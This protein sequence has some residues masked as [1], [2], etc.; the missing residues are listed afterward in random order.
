MK[1]GDLLLWVVVVVV[2]TV[3]FNVLLHSTGGGRVVH[4]VDPADASEVNRAFHAGSHGSDLLDVDPESHVFLTEEEAEAPADTSPPN[5][6]AAPRPLR[7]IDY[8]L[9]P[10]SSTKHVAAF[11][12][13]SY[14]DYIARAALTYKSL[15]G[16]RFNKKS[17]N[18]T[19]EQY[20]KAISEQPQC[21][22]KPVFMSM[23]RVSSD[24]YW[25]LIENFFH[26]MYYFGNVVSEGQPSM[27][28]S[29]VHCITRCVCCSQPCISSMSHFLITHY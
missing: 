13:S 26:T 5:T 10:A 29:V 24:L 16:H 22:A 1:I 18:L 7:V 8:T 6:P 25:Q 21:A 28:L 12:D 17:L 2:S 19:L 15:S 3:L 23:A 20:M 9:A 4:E 11:N 27:V 14:H